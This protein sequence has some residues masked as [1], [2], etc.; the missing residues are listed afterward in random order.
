M[1]YFLKRADK[2]VTQ[3]LLFEMLVPYIIM[4]CLSTSNNVTAFAQK[5]NNLLHFSFR[6]CKALP[7]L[8]AMCFIS[9]YLQMVTLFIFSSNL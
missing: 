5:E 2:A 6:S 7:T 3:Q 1:V 4:L 8:R 9:E